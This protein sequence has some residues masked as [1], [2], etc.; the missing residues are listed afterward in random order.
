MHQK[1]PQIL[2][3]GIAWALKHVGLGIIKWK[4]TQHKKLPEY[5][6]RITLSVGNLMS[7]SWLNIDSEQVSDTTIKTQNSIA[8]KDLKN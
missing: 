6:Q 2:T 7:E 8:T 5:Y 1:I 4:P 3:D